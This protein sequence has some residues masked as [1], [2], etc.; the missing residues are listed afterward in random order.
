[1]NVRLQ[2]AMRYMPD[3]VI[4]DGIG[5]CRIMAW[6]ANGSLTVLSP[7]GERWL[8]ATDAYSW[9]LWEGSDNDR[10]DIAEGF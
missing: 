10:A 5:V 4:V 9:P 2:W 3:E 7:D 8:V 6:H 1:M